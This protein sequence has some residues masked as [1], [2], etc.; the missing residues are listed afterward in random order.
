MRARTDYEFFLGA[1]LAAATA[2]QLLLIAGGSLGVVP[3]SGVV[4]PFLSYGRTAMLANFAV[5]GIL[6][7]ISIAAGKST[8][9]RRSAA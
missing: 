7:A 5:L 1:G 6:E 8:P 3:L 2:L 4:T 9:P